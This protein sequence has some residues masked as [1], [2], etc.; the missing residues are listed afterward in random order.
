MPKCT[1]LERL[2]QDGER[3]RGRVARTVAEVQDRH[4]EAILNDA[5][6]LQSVVLRAK[7]HVEDGKGRAQFS[8]AANRFD[9]RP[10][11]LLG[12]ISDGVQRTSNS[13]GESRPIACH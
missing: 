8:R 1:L 11:D 4:I 7:L 12:A 3:R 9:A 13:G 5:G 6:G 2:R 10:L